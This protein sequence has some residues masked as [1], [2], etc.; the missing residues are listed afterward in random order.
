MRTLSS[1][2]L[3]LGTLS[4]GCTSRAV[5]QG[6]KDLCADFRCPTGTLRSFEF[7]AT[8]G[9]AVNTDIRTESCD[10]DSVVFQ[11]EAR[12]AARC[13]GICRPQPGY[14][15]HGTKYCIAGQSVVCARLEAECFDP[16]PR[17]AIWGHRKKVRQGEEVER[18]LFSLSAA[19]QW[20][21][22][23]LYEDGNNSFQGLSLAALSGYSLADGARVVP[24][25]GPM[26]QLGLTPVAASTPAPYSPVN[27]V[28]GFM[29][30]TKRTRTESGGYGGFLMHAGLGYAY[31][32]FPRGSTRRPGASGRVQWGAIGG[33]VVADHT[34]LGFHVQMSIDFRESL[35]DLP[36]ELGVGVLW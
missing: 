8:G 9:D 21:S 33:P 32:E 25:Y 24:V 10:D 16:V 28:G 5:V 29:I 7:S 20:Y 2:A 26:L 22:P 23:T 30:G 15:P 11:Y 36:I 3:V 17:S 35:V 4:L 14:C 34:I 19:T 27:L 31:T 1:A 13:L 12:A 18:W 6:A